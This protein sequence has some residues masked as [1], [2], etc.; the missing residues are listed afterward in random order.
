MRWA[1]P[2]T[3]GVS[4]VYFPLIREFYASV[5][6]GLVTL[7]AP[8]LF[9]AIMLAAAMAWLVRAAGART[10]FLLSFVFILA[11][12]LVG[13]VSGA[14]AGWTLE[15]IVGAV[16]AAV[17]G[18]VSSLLAYLFGKET[19]RAW[20]PV[21]PLAIAALLISTLVGLVLG[22]SR[23]SQ[24]MN[25]ADSIAREKAE[26]ERVYLP[27]EAQ[28]RSAIMKRCIDESAN[29]TEAADCG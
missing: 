11:F 3:D 19:L 8:A 4:S 12:A 10:G 5:A 24:V 15:G 29:A 20:R 18:M 9:V 7:V 13:V 2:E 27:V 28:R 16:L 22:G 25:Q 1:G 6:F 17:L 14:V 23:R 26:F 21:I